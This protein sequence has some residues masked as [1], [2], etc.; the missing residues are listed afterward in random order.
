MLGTWDLLPSMCDLDEVIQLVTRM[1]PGTILELTTSI[2]SNVAPPQ[3]LFGDPIPEA[4]Y[5][6]GTGLLQMR[7]WHLSAD[8]LDWS[9]RLS[10]HRARC[11]QERSSHTFGAPMVFLQPFLAAVRQVSLMTR[12]V[13]SIS[14]GDELFLQTR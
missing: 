5:L 4:T 2:G 13:G 7:K 1:M 12:E 10:A 8:R 14:P 3:F 9:S 6:F 11:I